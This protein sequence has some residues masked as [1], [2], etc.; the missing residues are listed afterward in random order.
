MSDKQKTHIKIGA[1]EFDA[2]GDKA[3]VDEHLREFKALVEKAL[4][5]PASPNKLL[6]PVMQD[7]VVEP[8]ARPDTTETAVDPALNRI[9]K[10]DKNIVSLLIRPKTKAFAADSLLILLFGFHQ[11]L[12]QTEV[13]GGHLK[14]AAR[15]SGIQL[16]RVDRVLE[17]H[18]ALVDKGGARK[19]ARYRLNNPG[20][21]KAKEIMKLMQT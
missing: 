20:I 5:A 1:F 11:I 6:A 19:G 2:E 8:P 16:D 9:F 4:T 10:R 14:I 12:K 13:L 3:T 18:T 15:Q 21:E 17:H 7:T